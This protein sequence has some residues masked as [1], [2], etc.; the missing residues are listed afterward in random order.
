MYDQT[1]PRFSTHNS[2]GRRVSRLLKIIE[3]F[4]SQTKFNAHLCIKYSTIHNPPWKLGK[5][6]PCSSRLICLLSTNELR[7]D[8]SHYWLLIQIGE[9]M[10]GMRFL[11]YLGSGCRQSS[12]SPHLKSSHI[13]SRIQSVTVDCVFANTQNAHHRRE[14]NSHGCYYF[15]SLFRLF[16]NSGWKVFLINFNAFHQKGSHWCIT[17]YKVDT[18]NIGSLMPLCAYKAEHPISAV[19]GYSWT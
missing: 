15:F 5:R 3:S 18:S 1:F 11:Q 6:I 16:F 2:W 4:L 19:W 10:K 7:T 13:S 14:K 12:P 9:R 17:L 8:E